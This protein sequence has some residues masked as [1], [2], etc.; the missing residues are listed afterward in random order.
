MFEKG[1]Q[2]V[3]NIINLTLIEMR[4]N[5]FFLLIMLVISGCDYVHA[6]NKKVPGVIVS[7]IAQTEEKY[8]GSPSI[9]ILP[10]GT[11][12]ASHDEF[13]TK[14]DEETAAV[15][16]VFASYDR[17]QNW[18]CIATM[19]GQ[20]WSTLFTIKGKVYLIGTVKAHGAIVIRCSTDGGH[21]WTT[22]KD[23]KTGLL[24]EGEFHTAPMPLIV[25]K[26]RIWRAVENA[27]SPDERWPYRYSAMMMSAKVGSN[28][29]KASNW[30]FTNSLRSDTT[31]LSNRFKGWLEGNAVVA[32]DGQLYD[33]LRC[34]VEP[35]D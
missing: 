1:K 19:R 6:Q 5:H 17:G 32:P 9:C 35:N 10:D 2:R 11:Y 18:Q 3:E 14:S 4:I 29:L 28:L 22:P 13:G 34:E 30:R 12:L 21:T 25:H 7:H 33:V 26:G 24:K 27:S 15:T 8:I 16:R 20:F 23:K 31:C